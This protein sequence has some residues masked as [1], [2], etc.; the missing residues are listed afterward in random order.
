MIAREIMALTSGVVFPLIDGFPPLT[1]EAITRILI[2]I[3]IIAIVAV[4]SRIFE[5]TMRR[6]AQRGGGITVLQLATVGSAAVWII[7]ILLA[8]R[9]LGLEIDILLLVLGL[10]TLAVVLASREIVANWVA[11]Y[12][13]TTYKIF[14]LGDWIAVGRHYGRVAKMN[15]VDTVIVTPENEKVIIP[16]AILVKNVVVNRTGPEGFRLAIPFKVDRKLS[17]DKVEKV[18]LEVG[19]EMKDQLLQGNE[20]E[21]N[22]ARLDDSFVD[23]N[24]VLSIGNPARINSVKS[25]A[26]KKIKE[27]MDALTKEL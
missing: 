6:I 21:V 27:K 11:G 22:A 17:L 19:K 5:A 3:A 13:V 8:L 15:S 16:N 1:P 7:G 2:F 4:L 9:E 23:M 26:I 20:P 12:V 24:L 14:K 10:G 25:E 18:A